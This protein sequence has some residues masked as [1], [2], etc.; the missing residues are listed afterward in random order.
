MGSCL[1][2]I[3]ESSQ[4]ELKTFNK[5]NENFYTREK[6]VVEETAKDQ[7][8]SIISELNI[9]N[10]IKKKWNI[11]KFLFKDEIIS[12]TAKA[13][14]Q[15]S[16]LY[17]MSSVLNTIMN[18][19]ELFKL[20]LEFIKKGVKCDRGYVLMREH[21]EIK[22]KYKSDPRDTLV[23]SR[24]IANK[25]MNDQIGIIT[26]DAG[27]DDRFESSKSISE[28]SITS[29]MCVPVWIKEKAVGLLYLDN[30]ISHRRFQEED[31]HF[32]T[33]FASQLSLSL[34]KIHFIETIKNEEKVRNQLNRY[35][36]PDVVKTMLNNPEKTRL[37]GERTEVVVLFA[38]IRNFT[39]LSQTIPVDLLVNIINEY[40]S[41][42]VSIVFKHKGTIDKFIGDEI[43]AVFGAPISYKDNELRAVN[44]AVCIQKKMTELRKDWHIK[45]G[46]EFLIGIGIS[47]GLVIAGNVGSEERMDYTI[48]GNPVNFASR[49]CDIAPGDEIW[50]SEEVTRK[51]R[52]RINTDE[53]EPVSIKGFDKPVSLFRINYRD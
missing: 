37:G 20:A 52:N 46:V 16:I 38:D 45:F 36:S 17:E 27:E 28:F 7:T 41:C 2:Y 47:S 40:F 53:L 15:L 4:K 8:K 11:Y 22:C 6:E 13:Y 33:A 34:E 42:L 24:T 39:H 10:L 50:V 21:G 49:I 3:K 23:I 31:L 14:N 5:I 51:C 35:L 29:T 48:M 44:T 30:S 9:T 18:V 1:C 12:D 25:V 32:L 26:L 19:D 43:M